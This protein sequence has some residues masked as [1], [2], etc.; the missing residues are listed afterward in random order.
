MTSENQNHGMF[1]GFRYQTPPS[2]FLPQASES[3]RHS[4]R[5]NHLINH[6]S[7]TLLRIKI[8]A[9]D[10]RLAQ[11]DTF[12]MR[13]PILRSRVRIVPEFA[14]ELMLVQPEFLSQ[15]VLDRLLERPLRS[16]LGA[17]RPD[18]KLDPKG[19]VLEVFLLRTQENRSIIRSPIYSR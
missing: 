15:K 8:L 13:Q 1:H 10:V 19:L 18:G 6:P 3:Q 2:D 11:P 16:L 9:R 5:R 4:P 17:K 7:S 14:L 12:L